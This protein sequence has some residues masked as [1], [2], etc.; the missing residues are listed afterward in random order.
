MPGS[1]S[2]RQPQGCKPRS[3]I[4][5]YDNPAEVHRWW[6]IPFAYAS[7]VRSNSHGTIHLPVKEGLP[8]KWSLDIHKV[9]KK[10]VNATTGALRVYADGRWRFWPS[11][12]LAVPAVAEESRVFGTDGN[13]FTAVR[14]G[15]R[16]PRRAR[17]RPKRFDD[18]TW[19]EQN[20]GANCQEIW[21]VAH[22]M[23]RVRG[24]PI[25]QGHPVPLP[26]EE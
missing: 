9:Q 14:T 20:V 10:R 19:D 15:R 18:L 23:S 11:E 22:T 6:A 13:E 5:W 8:T 1:K 4:P 24:C 7:Q 25:G 12:V 2:K 26:Y 21:T 3:K 16:N 17:K